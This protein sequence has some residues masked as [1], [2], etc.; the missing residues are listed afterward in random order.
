M[1]GHDQALEAAKRRAREREAYR[2]KAQKDEADLRV[3]LYTA[4]ERET[5]V[6]SAPS[7]SAPRAAKRR[8]R[9]RHEIAAEEDAAYMRKKRVVDAAG[10]R[11]IESED[12]EDEPILNATRIV[13]AME[14]RTERR[15][16]P[17]RA[18]GRPEEKRETGRPEEK[19]DT[20]QI[21]GPS[22]PMEKRMPPRETPRSGGARETAP[23]PEL[24][25]TP[26]AA[27]HDAEAYARHMQTIDTVRQVSQ[28]TGREARRFRVPQAEPSHGAPPA[29]VSNSDRGTMTDVSIKLD[30]HTMTDL[31]DRRAN[32]NSLSMQIAQVHIERKEKESMDRQTKIGNLTKSSATQLQEAAS[33]NDATRVELN[34]NKQALAY[35]QREMTETRDRMTKEARKSAE[36]NRALQQ[37]LDTSA[38]TNASLLS[39]REMANVDQ[40]VSALRHSEQMHRISEL[41]CS[42]E[43]AR[44]DIQSKE[45]ALASIRAKLHE[46]DTR[47]AALRGTSDVQAKQ[48]SDLRVTLDRMTTELN[49]ANAKYE[50][51]KSSV[52][53]L[54]HDQK[55]IVADSAAT[56]EKHLDTIRELRVIIVNANR[57][58]DDLQETGKLRE[59]TIDELR[60]RLDKASEL[61]QVGTITALPKPG[62]EPG[63]NESVWRSLAEDSVTRWKL[64]LE[65]G[66]NRSRANIEATVAGAV[67]AVI[68]KFYSERRI[69][70]KDTIGAL[71]DTLRTNFKWMVLPTRR[72]VQGGMWV[73]G[74]HLAV[75][76]SALLTLLILYLV[77]A[78]NAPKGHQAQIATGD[79]SDGAGLSLRLT[80][81]PTF[82]IFGIDLFRLDTKEIIK[83]F[84]EFLLPGQRPSNNPIGAPP[85]PLGL[86]A[87]QEATTGTLMLGPAGPQVDAASPPSALPLVHGAGNAEETKAETATAAEDTKAAGTLLLGLVPAPLQLSAPHG[88]A[89]SLAAYA[90][91]ETDTAA[92]TQNENAL[93]KPA[94]SALEAAALEA[95]LAPPLAAQ[96]QKEARE[97]LAAQKQ[98][99]ARE[100]QKQ[101]QLEAAAQ[102][103]A[104]QEAAALEAA[105]KTAAAQEAAALET[106]ALEAAKKTAAALEAARKRPKVARSA[107]LSEDDSERTKNTNAAAA[108]R[109]AAAKL[110]TAKAAIELSLSGELVDEYTRLAA[111]TGDANLVAGWLAGL[112]TLDATQVQ[113]LKATIAAWITG[114]D[115][116]ISELKE[117]EAAQK[118][119]T[120]A[121][122]KKA[123]KKAD[124]KKADQKKADAVTAARELTAW[125]TLGEENQ[126]R[127]LTQLQLYHVAAVIV[128]STSEEEI[129]KSRQ[130]LGEINKKLPRTNLATLFRNTMVN[131]EELVAYIAANE[132][133][134]A[135]QKL[136]EDLTN[137]NQYGW[138]ITAGNYTTEAK[139]LERL[140]KATQ[141][142]VNAHFPALRFVSGSPSANLNGLFD[143]C[144]TALKERCDLL[145]ELY[146]GYAGTMIYE[147]ETDAVKQALVA[148]IMV[149]K[150]IHTWTSVTELFDRTINDINEGTNY[151]LSVIIAATA[152]L[153]EGRVVAAV[154][155]LI[156]YYHVQIMQIPK[157]STDPA[158]IAAVKYTEELVYTS[159]RP[160]NAQYVCNLARTLAQTLKSLTEENVSR[161]LSFHHTHR[162]IARTWVDIEYLT[163]KHYELLQTDEKKEALYKEATSI[164][165]NLKTDLRKL[166]ISD[167]R[168]TSI[169]AYIKYKLNDNKKTKERSEEDARIKR[170]AE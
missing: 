41:R 161:D 111:A 66:I 12:E 65:D 51:I 39:E 14:I 33:R 81:P 6:P 93:K 150:K 127:V 72:D 152:H 36:E 138:P 13:A 165:D 16:R 43:E 75:L 139:L 167:T 73:V 153:G 92:T 30:Q 85:V 56:S 132:P 61:N 32:L 26:P 49:T 71:C 137:G 7:A 86:S 107:T 164:V 64:S 69:L 157:A 159:A 87:M 77:C 145:S 141:P 50:V 162:I 133:E 10:L 78:L 94:K 8:K 109:Q 68:G 120:E 83:Y 82:D 134:N 76:A 3:M 17:E 106:A 89:A 25:R 38:E 119:A 31:D 156:V 97:A 135:I 67:I 46:V 117:K 24:I 22:E 84:V 148:S 90:A 170:V 103:A 128:G 104:A 113:E 74:Q 118:K 158:F 166:T 130:A 4:P 91:E 42:L 19:I 62:A 102:E 58:I 108:A 9:N 154:R 1:L 21:T 5:P 53:K 54:A 47:E 70:P 44:R 37:S 129:T 163:L 45:D 112:A 131:I 57:S 168:H 136:A 140:N 60:S 121:D 96:Q 34:A 23:R 15:E 116:A 28:V 151:M 29:A 123:A 169:V 149:A 160:N 48:N 101:Q 126:Q 27:S 80:E 125:P 99:E 115:K 114:I 100:A 143:G 95:T 124:P 52:V 88:D 18:A 146:R 63:S 110:K 147:E 59:D 122:Q 55:A 142:T 11:L 98:R 155:L 144:N 35:A 40:V 105:K 2:K 20:E 79:T